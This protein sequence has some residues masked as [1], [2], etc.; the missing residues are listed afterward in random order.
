MRNLRH[1][2]RK[3]LLSLRNHTP[4][5]AVITLFT[6]VVMFFILAMVATLFDS[7]QRKEHVQ[8]QP[9]WFKHY[10]HYS[11][12]AYVQFIEDQISKDQD[13]TLAAILTRD[14]YPFPQLPPV[15]DAERASRSRHRLADFRFPKRV[16]ASRHPRRIFP[17]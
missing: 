15:L 9:H 13:T 10:Q 16:P 7:C 4:A 2:L 14:Y 6:M 17:T 8:P 11:E 1:K 5:A 12:K 3:T